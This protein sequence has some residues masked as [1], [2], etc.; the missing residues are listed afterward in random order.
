[1]ALRPRLEIVGQVA[2]CVC[3]SM[4]L[5]A[6]GQFVYGSY[7]LF[8][9]LSVT[10]GFHLISRRPVAAGAVF[11]GAIPAVMLLRGLFL[12]NAPQ[13]MLAACFGAALLTSDHEWRRLRKNSA[14]IGT[15][16][17]CFVYWL[18]S[19]L[20]TG[21]YS[22]S[23]RLIEL[24]LSAAVVFIVAGYRSY[25][26][27]ALIG[28]VLSA[29]AMAAGLLPHGTRL[30]IVTLA[31]GLSIGNPIAMGVSATIGYLFSIADRGRWM[32]LQGHFRWR[33]ALNLCAAAALVLSTSRGSWLVTVIGLMVLLALNREGR[34]TL[35]A[36]LFCGA[37]MIGLIL[38]TGRGATVA[39]YFDNAVA[40]DKSIEKRTTGRADQWISFPKV[41]DESPLWGFGPGSGKAVSLRFTKE[42]KVWHSLYLLIGAET[43]LIGL[44]LLFLLLGYLL[45][46]A[47]VRWNLC[48]EIAPLL[49]LIC[50]MVI[51]VSVSGV[52]AISGVFLGVALMANDY[53]GFAV[54]RTGTRIP[55]VKIE[56]LEWQI[57]SSHS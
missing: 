39:H 37:L 54:L 11:T 34:P 18:V 17:F 4:L 9:M 25:M 8:G 45:K 28:L 19:V 29:V 47:W 23:I 42:G 20:L 30:G 55:A 22:S 5:T 46:S 48:G 31:S 13:F 32:L 50:Y 43:G 16:I 2:L 40:A 14:L 15:M 33:L 27:S 35:L 38:Q 7:W 52:D 1:M 26:A 12:Y 56:E 36:S 51:G 57:V 53:T 10:L 44:S 49:S 24:A 6:V 41:F 21:D 3:P